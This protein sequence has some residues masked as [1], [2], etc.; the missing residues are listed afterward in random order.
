MAAGKPAPPPIGRS[1]Q[2]GWPIARLPGRLIGQWELRGG[3][4]GGWGHGLSIALLIK[5]CSVSLTCAFS[6]HRYTAFNFYE[7]KTLTSF[8]LKSREVI[9][10]CTSLRD[11]G[12]GW[13]QRA[14]DL[15]RA[16]EHHRPTLAYAN[17]ED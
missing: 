17:S 14:L 15:A 16:R 10:A 2:S 8:L 1:R 11:V 6:I 5:S 12:V 13:S 9:Q 4:E 3:A 7:A